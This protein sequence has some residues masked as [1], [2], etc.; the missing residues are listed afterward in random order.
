MS[1]T[2]GWTLRILSPR[3]TLQINPSQDQLP[4]WL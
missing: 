1:S 3:T 4:G 2:S